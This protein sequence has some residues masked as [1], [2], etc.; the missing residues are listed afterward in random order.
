LG[1]QVP[2]QDWEARFPGPTLADAILDR[3]MY[4]AYRPELKG[5]SMR[6][7]RLPTAAARS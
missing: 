3:L 6:K 7:A 2:L 5:G 1:A 4:I